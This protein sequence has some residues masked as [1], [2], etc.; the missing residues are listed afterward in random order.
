MEGIK[1]QCEERNKKALRLNYNNDQQQQ[2][3]T[4]TNTNMETTSYGKRQKVEETQRA[5]TA[6]QAS[7]RP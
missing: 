7:P 3:L 6:S 2:D 4:M 1:H 5:G